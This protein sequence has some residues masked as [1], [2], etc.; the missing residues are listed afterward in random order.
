MLSL[1]VQVFRTI[2]SLNLIMNT[3][4]TILLLINS[5]TLKGH[6]KEDLIM[7]KY[8][9]IIMYINLGFNILCIVNFL[10][11]SKKKHHAEEVI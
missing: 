3:T 1:V 5:V 10:F 2:F 9:I 7:K 4:T 11:F 8:M 6:L